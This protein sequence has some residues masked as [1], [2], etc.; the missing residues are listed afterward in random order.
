MEHLSKIYRSSD[1]KI[2]K[3]INDGLDAFPKISRTLW[4]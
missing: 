2:E 1:P 3:E 4:W